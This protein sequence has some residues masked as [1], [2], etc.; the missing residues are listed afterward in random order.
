MKNRLIII[1][2]FLVASGCLPEKPFYINT[3]KPVVAMQKDYA[4]C[5]NEA[6]TKYPVRMNSFETSPRF[7]SITTSCTSYSGVSSYT[8]RCSSSGGY[9][10]SKTEWYDANEE[11]RIE[12]NTQCIQKRGY[13]IRDIPYCSSQVPE[14]QAC[15]S[16]VF[17]QD[18]VVKR[19]D[20]MGLGANNWTTLDVLT[21]SE[22]KLLGVSGCFKNNTCTELFK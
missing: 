13:R 7:D 20:Q 6:R 10:P 17:F 16:S 11:N 1:S 19:G 22:S 18:G 15:W 12:Y 14:G 8:T 5:A 3:S 21:V 9:V 4:E 2:A